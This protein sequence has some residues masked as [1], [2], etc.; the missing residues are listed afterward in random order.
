AAVESAVYALVG[1]SVLMLRRKEPDLARPF[2]VPGGA[3]VPLATAVVFGGLAAA[4]LATDRRAL[5]YLVLG[6][7]VSAAYVRL[8]VPRLRE[9][10]R[11]ARLAR[12]R[13]A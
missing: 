13:Q 3:A 9:R 1:L 12:R 11:R 10:A 7:A 8:V 4:V 5:V 2:F 6:L